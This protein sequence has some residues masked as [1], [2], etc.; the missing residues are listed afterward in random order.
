M[1]PALQN[2][3]IELAVPFYERNDGSHNVPHMMSVLQNVLMLQAIEGGDLDILIPSAI[4]HDCTKYDPR[5]ER[6]PFASEHSA[7]IAVGYL[8][9]LPEFPA[10]KISRVYAVILEHSTSAKKIATSLESRILQDADRLDNTGDIGIQRI[11]DAT[12]AMNCLFHHPEDPFAENRPLDRK[13]IAIDYLLEVQLNL[14]FNTA[15]AQKMA[16]P[17]FE[18]MTQ[19]LESFARELN[20]PC[21]KKYILAHQMA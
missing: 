1:T 14:N 7:D 2:T 18:Q 13:N 16:Q 10:E 20:V 6:A 9:Q 5:D 11:R 21:P 17:R 4:F 8:A 15:T 3:L 12:Q 19:F